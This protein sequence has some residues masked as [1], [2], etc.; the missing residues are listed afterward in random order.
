[1]TG[2]AEQPGRPRSVPKYL[3]LRQQLLDEINER[4]GPDEMMPGERELAERFG[5]SRMTVRQAL[6]ALADDGHIYSIRGQGTFVA[7]A[8]ITKPP[9]LT[10]FSGDMR[11]RGLMPGSR[12]LSAEIVSAAGDV[13]RDLEL[14]PGTQVYRIGRVRLA[15][16]V[17]MCL[18]EV[19]LPVRLFPG[20]LDLD[21]SGSLYELLEQRYRTPVVAADQITTAVNLTRTRAELLGVPTRSAALKVVRI[22]TDNRGRMVERA[23]S[24]YR[25]DR[26]DFSTRISRS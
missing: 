7:R 24:L 25:G 9:T 14:E 1:M 21:L 11:A 13:A 23:V 8:R 17:P 12:L 3:R 6:T 19:H 5:V 26:Y 4:F 22:S 2:M 18:E 16:D 20:L 10:S 15:D